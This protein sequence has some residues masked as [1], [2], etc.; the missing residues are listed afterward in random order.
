[1]EPAFNIDEVITEGSQSVAE[2]TAAEDLNKIKPKM[3]TDQHIWGIYIS[4]LIISVIEL[5]SASSQEVQINDIYGP[6]IRH[7]R[8]LAIGLVLMLAIQKFHFKYIYRLT[9]LYVFGSIM[10]MLMVLGMGVKVNGAQRAIQFGSIMI[11]PAEFLKLAAAL[12]IAYI[13]SR[14]QMPGKRDVTTKGVVSSAV[15]TLVCAGLLFSHGLTNTLLIFAI[16]ISMMLIG[17]VGMKKFLIVC[18]V[19]GLIG[20]AAMGYKLWQNKGAAPS[21]EAIEIA[22][23]NQEEVGATSGNRSSTW[24]ARV[25]RHFRLNKAGDKID[26][27]NKQEQLSYIAQAHGGLTGV[28]PGN[29]RENA[30]LPLAFS[31]YIYAIVIEELGLVT[32]IFV[33]LCYLWLLARAG[34]VATQCK[35]TFPCLLVIGCAIYIVYQALFHMAIVTGVFPVSGQPLPLI[36]KGGTSVIVTSIALGIMLSTSRHAAFKD[37]KEAIRQELNNLPASIHSDNP[38][39]L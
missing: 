11:L 12:G 10:A 20:A 18:C 7:A 23:L 9:P 2:T 3:R 8:F 38:S 35:Q 21:P 16:S 33:L 26:D 17:G 28:G 4:L 15:F 30:R 5:F 1:M 19:Y 27:T 25:Q 13:L 37:D 39:Q 29:S 31:D 14:T 32:G 22:E 34:R 6:I 24:V 36:S